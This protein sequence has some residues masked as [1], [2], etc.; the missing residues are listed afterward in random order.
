MPG[1]RYQPVIDLGCSVNYVVSMNLLGLTYVWGVVDWFHECSR[2]L[3][4]HGSWRP[5]MLFGDNGAAYS[6]F[7]NRGPSIRD[8]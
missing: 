1:A 7:Q 5:W 2:Q 4:L 8:T 6:N 3:R